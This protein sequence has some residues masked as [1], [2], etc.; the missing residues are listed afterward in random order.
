MLIEDMITKVKVRSH[1]TSK[2]TEG[3]N[4]IV[5]GAVTNVANWD[6]GLENVRRTE[7]LEGIK[8]RMLKVS[9]Q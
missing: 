1:L 2:I 8:G 6:T 3:K 9:C 5:K 4:L 7:V